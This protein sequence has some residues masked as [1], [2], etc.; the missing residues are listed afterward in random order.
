[1]DNVTWVIDQTMI[2]TRSFTVRNQ[3][4]LVIENV[5]GLLKAIEL[6]N[7][8]EW[9]EL[10][11]IYP[12]V[13]PLVLWDHLARRDPSEL[14]S[15][16]RSWSLCWITWITVIQV[17][18]PLT[19]PTRDLPCLLPW[20]AVALMQFLGLIGHCV[21]GLAGGRM[22]GRNTNYHLNSLL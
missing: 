13:L 16:S 3:R 21:P 6:F 15:P 2:V 20:S 4:R 19:W 1:M 5:V 10:V 7:P 14:G 8:K 12:S 17:S 9:T 22:L 18:L 11:P